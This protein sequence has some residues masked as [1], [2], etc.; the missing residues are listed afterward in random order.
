MDDL[1]ATRGFL[2]DWPDHSRMD[3]V[4]LRC[5][6]LETNLSVSKIRLLLHFHAF[7][8]MTT[9]LEEVDAAASLEDLFT[10]GGLP[11][12]SSEDITVV[13]DDPRQAQVRLALTASTP[14]TL[15]RLKRACAVFFHPQYRER[16]GWGEWQD[17]RPVP[18]AVRD[19]FLEMTFP[20]GDYPNDEALNLAF[21]DT[22]DMDFGQLMA[23]IDDDYN[24]IMD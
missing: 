22:V 13:N 15:H 18:Q 7:E 9:G 20:D 14:S 6:A 21:S 11:L 4:N 10:H 24:V 16:H 3:Y 12:V 1:S 17:K 8:R 23:L 2:A 19:T 5:T